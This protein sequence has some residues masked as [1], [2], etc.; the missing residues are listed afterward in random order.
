MIL[1]W[2]VIYHMT[3]GSLIEMEE[4]KEEKDEEKYLDGGGG[5]EDEMEGEEGTRKLTG[6]GGGG[7]VIWICM[8]PTF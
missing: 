1:V 8:M 4:R 5:E 2:Q 7:E 3:K 6:I